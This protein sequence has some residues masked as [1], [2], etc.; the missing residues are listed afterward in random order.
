MEKE[1]KKLTLE[2]LLEQCEG[3][4][5]HLGYFDDPP[6]GIELI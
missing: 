6:V 3:E 5:P 1:E 4:N 2:E